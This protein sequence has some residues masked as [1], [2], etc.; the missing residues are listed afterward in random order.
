MLGS[1]KC[2]ISVIYQLASKPPAEDYRGLCKVYR[3]YTNLSTMPSYF[4]AFLSIPLAL[5]SVYSARTSYYAIT[6]L[7]R[8]EERSE[9]AARHFDK[10]AHDLHKTR[11]TQASGAAAVR[12]SITRESLRIPKATVSTYLLREKSKYSYWPC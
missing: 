7:Q 11:T 12:V 10:A 3:Y 6:N 4:I 1:A 8:Y 2:R 5:L 9:K